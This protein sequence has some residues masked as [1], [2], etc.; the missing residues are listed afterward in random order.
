MIYVTPFEAAHLTRMQ[1]QP[2]QVWAAGL[3]ETRDLHGLEGPYSSTLM[4][5]G[6]PLAC[7]G[8]LE[9]WPNRALVWSFISAQINAQRFWQ[10]HAEAR[11]FL[12]GLPFKRLEASV[13]VGFKAGHRWL[14]SLGFE[15]E[16]PL[17]RCF[18]PHGGD[19][20][21]YVRIRTG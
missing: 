15:V 6:V 3:I 19:S 10:L 18:Q 9:Y 4:D 20:V 14:L 5:G 1:L 13:D 7:A 17:Q 12:D 21:G 11:R 8:A 16:A 2:A